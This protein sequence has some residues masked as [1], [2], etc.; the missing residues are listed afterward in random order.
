MSTHCT[1]LQQH[2][3]TLFAQMALVYRIQLT[4]KMGYFEKRVNACKG[5]ILAWLTL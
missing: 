5:A 1:A 2:S 4:E 3:I